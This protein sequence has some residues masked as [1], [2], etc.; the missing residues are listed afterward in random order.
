MPQIEINIRTN[1]DLAGFAKTTAASGALGKSLGDLGGR[2]EHMFQGRHLATAV[3]SAVGINIEKI[4]QGIARFVT[5]VSEEEE[6]AFKAMEG[7]SEKAADLSIKNMQAR[8]SNEQLLKTALQERAKLQFELDNSQATTAVELEEQ[9]KK[10]IKLEELVATVRELQ[11]KK[12]GEAVQVEEQLA[13]A[14]QHLQTVQAN[15][16]Q[17]SFQKR[18]HEIALMKDEVVLREKLLEI[19]KTARLEGGE[20]QGS[21]DAKIAKL[22]E[23]NQR[24]RDRIHDLEFST[25]DIKRHQGTQSKYNE[26]NESEGGLDGK[27]SVVG[28]AK[29][30]AMDWV[31]KLGSQAGQVA[32]AIESTIGTAVTGIAAGIDGWINGTKSFSQSAAQ[33]GGSILKS[34]LHTVVQMGAQWLVNAVLIKTGMIS[35]ETTGDTLRV[36]RVAKENAA[37]A[38]TLPMKTA[39]AAASGISSFGIALAFGLIAIALIAGLAGGFADG[40]FTSPGGANEVAGVVHRGEWVAP[41]WMVKDAGF[42]QVIA[43]LEGARRGAHGFDMGG[44]TSPG[45]LLTQPGYA[46]QESRPSKIHLYMDPS[47]YARAMQEHMGDH[48]QEIISR[49]FRQ[50]A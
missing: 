30:G 42:G 28:A 13:A 24:L 5:G 14:A 9:L 25:P 46:P 36:G 47:E 33:I 20:T 43:G 29:D 49:E 32:N 1:A 34:M 15:P 35:I 16:N 3:A 4:A 38:A 10:R 41:Q 12:G 21:H 6:K 26:M 48:F 40:G 19:L 44:F 2:L 18:D 37:E 8:L 17:T 7:L 27:F 11:K 50:R 23:E 45:R 22:N 39:G 31:T